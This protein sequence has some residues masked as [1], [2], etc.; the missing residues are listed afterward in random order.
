MTLPNS[1]RFRLG[2]VILGILLQ[3]LYAPAAAAAEEDGIID[4]LFLGHSQR[5]GDGYH[6]SHVYAPI[7]NRSLGKEKI[8]MRYEEDPAVLNEADLGQ[9]DVL[10]IYANHNQLTEAQETAL[11][12]FV[13]EGGGFLPIHCASACFEHSDRYV[14]L[15]GARF[16]SHGYES[17]TA[18]IAEG[19]ETHA[20][21]R[22]YDSFETKDETYVHADH[23][24]ENREVLMYREQEPWTWTREQGKGR[25]FYTAWG[26]DHHTWEHEAF[27]DLLV[28]GIL[29]SVGEE[30]AEANRALVASLPE[31]QYEEADTI[32]NYRR[33]WPAPDLA[34]PFTPEES[35]E[36]SMAQAGFDLKLFA[37]EPDIVNPVAFAWD[38][39]GR[40]FVAETVDYPNT[41][42]PNQQ[43]HDRITIC[44]DKDGDGKADTF[45]IFA[46]GLNI[47]TGLAPVDGGWI[48]AQA[49]RFLYLKDTDGDD[50]ADVK[51][52]L[53]E[54]WGTRDTHAGPSNLRY[55]H[56]NKIWGAVGYSEVE[57]TTQGGQFGQ[58]VFRMDPDG[59]NIEP[60][61]LFSNNTWGLGISEDFEIFGSTAN[62]APAWHVPLW[63]RFTYERHEALPS[64]LAAKIDDFSQFF[65]ATDNF[66]QVD[67]H[68]RYTAGSGFNVYTARSFPKRYWNRGAF[69]G[70]PTGHLLGQF[71]LEEDGSSYIAQNRGSLLASVDEWLSP[72]FAEVGPDGQL[73]VADWYNFIIQHNP[74]PSVDSAGFEAEMG[75]GNAHVNPLRDRQ[76]GRIY[77]IVSR[78]AKPSPALDLSGAS[79][80][81]LI[82]TLAND[83][84]FWRL[85]AQRKLVR[86]GRKEAIPELREIVLNDRSVDELG[87]NTRVIH[88]IWSL[89]G[90]ETFS[91]DTADG[92]RVVR[93]ALDHPSAAV[94]KNAVMA[95]TESGGRRNLDMASSLI[96]DPDAKTR[97][98]SVVAIGLLPSSEA[99][100]K[101]LFARR[102]TLPRDRWIGRAFAHAALENEEHYLN[103]LLTNRDAASGSPLDVY[104]N[105][106]DAPDYLVARRYLESVEGD[107][108]KALG[109]WQTLPTGSVGPISLALLDAWKTKLHE[110]TGR[111]VSMLQRMVDRLN[112]D[113]QMKLKLRSPGLSLTF[114]KIDPEAY[115]A[116]AK[117]HSFEP[118]VWG[119]GRAEDGAEIF[120]QHCVSCHGSEAQGDRS[121]EAP[122][123]AGMENWYTQVQLQKYKAGLRG[124][125]FKNPRGIAMR[126]ALELVQSEV[127][128]NRAFSHLAHYLETLP[129]IQSEATVEGDA[130]SGKVHYGLCVPCHG[131]AAQGNQELGAPK[132]TGKQDW[133]LLKHLQAFHEGV[134]GADPRDVTGGQMAA[135]AKA[136]PD[137]QAMKDVIVY[138]RSLSDAA[139]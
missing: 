58:G 115:A 90:L 77:R 8:R 29:W 85:T 27:H 5:E 103:E 38:E 7:L 43:G 133:Y 76:H 80:P 86:E 12:N 138:I 84:L 136:L 73:W 97:L 33:R 129:A 132:L 39:R 1:L 100:A 16:K 92:E 74:R 57:G 61:G 37:A 18:R 40:L 113:L 45:T 19:K 60:V 123:L 89:H 95:L 44:E 119:W 41:L 25:V 55:G 139:R 78:D 81:K 114:S 96:D 32:P 125:H 112:A 13:E 17:F 4:L 126:S 107:F 102:A 122:S 65:A 69:V 91:A 59:G 31:I 72:V 106:E 88:A 34:K 54:G 128:P 63:R 101:Q 116:Y 135:I 23:N 93:A 49:P 15:V 20:I 70:G 9:A 14:D 28:R 134:R 99:T 35:A 124:T 75:A 79:T 51:R 56:D 110:P 131:D 108:E 42:L 62:N 67:A 53:N 120:K 83:N 109:N 21:L 66:L 127:D 105:I 87:L 26:H 10:L 22:G 118:D 117:A 64:Q 47:P 46:E 6:L 82:E 48:V 121:L 3:G 130:A 36:L 98:K 50:R 104:E 2:T 24:D 111:E 11:L 137:E 71:F 68:G 30:K 94:R 52:V